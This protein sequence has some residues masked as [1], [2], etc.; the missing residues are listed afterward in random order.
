MRRN[1][2][3]ARGCKMEKQIRWRFAAGLIASVALIAAG[4][5]SNPAAAPQ[6]RSSSPAT[7]V[8]SQTRVAAAFSVRD[9]AGQTI[10][11]PSSDT[12]VLY[13]M[14]A[15]CGSCAV[16]ERRLADLQPLL[17]PGVRLVSLDV[18]PQTDTAAALNQL[19]ADAGAKWPQAFAPTSVLS[20]Y[21]VAYL[22]TVAVVSPSGRLVYEG[23]IPTSSNLLSIVRSAA[24]K[25]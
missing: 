24:G 9:T 3:T 10:A 18:T 23:P 12:T 22:D 20:A 1:L 15:W 6:H 21:K 11:V 17:P 19:A 5:G 7:S 8:R 16:G 25:D 13:F 4:C 2:E 14:A